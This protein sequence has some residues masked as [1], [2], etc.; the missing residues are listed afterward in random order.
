MRHV[1]DGPYQHAICDFCECDRTA[2][3]IKWIKPLGEKGIC[4]VCARQLAQ[5]LAQVQ[6][7]KGGSK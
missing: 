3:H 1:K 6:E 2:N 5:L 7:I 4:D